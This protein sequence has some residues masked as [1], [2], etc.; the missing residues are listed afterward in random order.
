MKRAYELT[1]G[2]LFSVSGVMGTSLGLNSKPGGGAS[3]IFLSSFSNFFSASSVELASVCSLRVA[4]SSRA[5][6]W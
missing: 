3:I 4:R 2:G 6:R 1:L 5:Q